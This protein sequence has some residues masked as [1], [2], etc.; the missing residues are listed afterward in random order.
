M[1][2]L[3]LLVLVLWTDFVPRLSRIEGRDGVLEV[4]WW[5]W[6]RNAFFSW[7]SSYFWHSNPYQTERKKTH[8]DIKWIY[9]HQFYLAEMTAIL[10]ISTRSTQTTYLPLIPLQ[11]LT[12]AR[13]CTEIAVAKGRWR[14]EACHSVCSAE[15]TVKARSEKRWNVISWCLVGRLHTRVGWASLRN[16]PSFTSPQIGSTECYLLSL[17]VIDY[18]CMHDNVSIHLYT[19]PYGVLQTPLSRP[20]TRSSQAIHNPLRNPLV[21]SLTH[22]IIIPPMATVHR[23]CAK[24]PC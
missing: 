14:C 18:R 8:L 6:S 5:V 3:C 9:H 22:T 19:Q 23:L 24:Q 2:Y 7:F 1:K 10:S 4:N 20:R 21:P 11:C 13:P 16:W 17:I 15:T 12:K